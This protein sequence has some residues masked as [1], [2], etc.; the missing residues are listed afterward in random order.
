[1][2][3]AEFGGGSQVSSERRFTL[4]KGGDGDASAA[5][6]SGKQEGDLGETLHCILPKS[7]VSILLERPL[8]TSVP[9][10]PRAPRPKTMTSPL[11]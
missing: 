3:E 8:A 4:Q 5:C 10:F 7:E 6:H 9:T 11:R 2:G 1:M